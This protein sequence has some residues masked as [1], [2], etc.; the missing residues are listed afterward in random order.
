MSVCL[1]RNARRLARHWKTHFPNAMADNTS[2]LNQAH[3]QYQ[4]TTEG[5]TVEKPA[6]TLRL[7][8]AI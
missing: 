7:A 6:E 4:S 8:S 2:L 3:V 1:L 5:S